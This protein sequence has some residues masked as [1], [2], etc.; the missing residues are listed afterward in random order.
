LYA[1]AGASV[2]DTML[3]QMVMAKVGYAGDKLYKEALQVAKADVQAHRKDFDR[4]S[5]SEQ[6]EYV[7]YIMAV[8]IIMSGRYE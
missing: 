8:Y 5:K 6:L 2:G 7:A 3:K 1:D 4:K